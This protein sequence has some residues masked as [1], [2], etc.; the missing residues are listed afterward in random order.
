MEENGSA[1]KAL[2]LQN[3]DIEVLRGFFEARMM[4][5]AHITDIWFAGRLEMAKKRVG[6]L[7]ASGLLRERPRNVNERAIL[8]LDNKGLRTLRDAGIIAEY[9]GSSKQKLLRR[10]QVHGVS[11]IAH[12]LAVMDAKAAF[13]RA[14]RARNVEIIEFVT[15]PQL[16]EFWVSMPRQKPRLVKPDGYLRVRDGSVESVFFL[17]VDMATERLDVLARKAELYLRYSQSGASDAFRVLIVCPSIE[18][19]ENIARRILQNVPPSLTHVHV[20]TMDDALAD[21]F[22]K[23]WARPVDYR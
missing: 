11:T 19:M 22:G 3:R 17:E 1:H 14:A 12:E 2:V 16:N 23:I 6:R 4:T 7:K 13:Y 5:V 20:A 18:R 10:A 9:P 8:Y 21:P 15:W